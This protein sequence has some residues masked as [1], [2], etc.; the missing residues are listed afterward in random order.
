MFDHVAQ[1]LFVGTNHN[2]F[3]VLLRG[4]FILTFMYLAR[5]ILAGEATIKAYSMSTN[6][7][8]INIKDVFF[9]SGNGFAKL[10]SVQFLNA[11]SRIKI[12]I[13]LTCQSRPAN[14]GG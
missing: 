14:C 4:I 5:E 8:L 9:D 7:S 12:T 2:D 3:K 11:I 1:P 13:W 6:L 10:D